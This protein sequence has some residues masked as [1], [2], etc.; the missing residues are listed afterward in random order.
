MEIKL[1]DGKYTYLFDEKTGI[2]EALRYDQKW[3]NTIGD[4]FILAMA[5][6]ID[7]LEKQIIEMLEKQIK[8]LELKELQR[9][10]N[11]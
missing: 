1:A 11:Q 9:G 5:Q 4:G 10:C 2:S 7:E 3:R 8:E 6:R